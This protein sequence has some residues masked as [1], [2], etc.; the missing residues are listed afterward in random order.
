MILFFVRLSLKIINVL[1]VLLVIGLLPLI[2]RQYLTMK[3]HKVSSVEISETKESNNRSVSLKDYSFVLRKN[4]FGLKG[5]ASKTPTNLSKSQTTTSIKGYK[6]LGTIA[7]NRGRGYAVIEPPS[8]GQQLYHVGQEVE[9]LGPL[10]E[11]WPGYALVGEPPKKLSLVDISE[12]ASRVSSTGPAPVTRSPRRTKRGLS[13]FNRFIRRR[14]PDEYVVDRQK[15]EEALEN[16]EQLMTDARLVPAFRNGKQYG[17]IL[18]S[19]KPNGIYSKLGLRNGD[20]L[21]K[22]NEF[23][24]TDPE[25]ALRAFNELRGADEIVLYIMR[26]GQKKTLRYIIE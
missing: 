17:F 9:G 7:D 3:T 24:I 10:K 1:T 4:P 2:L 19:V 13:D 23:D 25:T 11:V 22:I 18:R 21:M 8:G 14:G 15:V 6:L 12:L 16:P 20:V 26:G 5:T